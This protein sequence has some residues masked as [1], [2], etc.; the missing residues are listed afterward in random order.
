M[1]HV[2][3]PHPNTANE[4]G[5]V[6][7]GGDLKVPTLLSAYSHGIFPW[8]HEGY[9]LLWFSPWERGILEFKDFHCSRS[10][11]K[12][13]KKVSHWQFTMN[14][15]FQEVIK[16]CAHVSRKE[17]QGTW[18]NNEMLSSYT[19]FHKA[20]F[21]H[22]FEVWENEMLIGGI[23]GVFV[24]NVFSAESMFYKQDNASKWAFVKMIDHLKK[25]GLQWIDLQMVTPISE[26]F[27][28][29]L[30]SQSE[31]LQKLSESHKLSPLSITPN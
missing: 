10:L 5:I 6:A 12:F 24:K 17:A 25:S 7:V 28:A 19:D 2:Q 21:A 23:Y 27:G 31:F 18:I 8:P 11:K 16:N 26:S 14:N 4:D 29:K 1:S 30:I 22:S 20:G 3:F 13:T 15:S 9:P